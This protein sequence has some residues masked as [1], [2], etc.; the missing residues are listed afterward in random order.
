MG[1][2]NVRKRS[3][4]LELETEASIN[5]ASEYG[6]H[7]LRSK[8]NFQEYHVLTRP[9]MLFM[10]TVEMSVVGRAQNDLSSDAILTS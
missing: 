7:V 6:T 3:P 2:G 5:L 9:E 10:V 4:I 1:G 8:S